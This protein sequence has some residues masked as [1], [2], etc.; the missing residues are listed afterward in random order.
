LQ[1]PSK[2]GRKGASAMAVRVKKPTSEAA[3][4]NGDLEK[5][6]DALRAGGQPKLRG[7]LV[8]RAG[9]A[10]TIRAG[11]SLLEVPLRAVTNMTEQGQ[12][13]QL[14][15]APDAEVMV[16]TL[17]TAGKGFVADNVFGAL[18]DAGLIA[19]ACNCNCNCDRNAALLQAEFQSPDTLSACDERR[20]PSSVGPG[21]SLPRVVASSFRTRG[22]G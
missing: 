7:Q 5:R 20:V 14:S 10:L 2:L 11:G 16:H 12:D 1:G 18:V 13:V 4:S 3:M 19:T 9:D 6:F 8:T 17:V 22:T 15:L 21:V